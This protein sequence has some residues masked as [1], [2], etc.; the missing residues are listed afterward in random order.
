MA[1]ID[2]ERKEG[3]S[4]WGWLVGAL[5]VALLAWGAVEL[6]DAGEPELAEVEVTEEPGEGMMGDEDETEMRQQGM[7]MEN[8]GQATIAQALNNPEQW[9]SRTVPDATVPVVEVPTDRGFWVTT[10]G[11]RLFVILI[12]QPREEPKDINSGATVRLTGGTFRNADH[13]P[14]LEG[15][16]LDQQTRQ[17]AQGERIFLVVDERNVEIVDRVGGAM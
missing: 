2:L 17:M 6:M 13:L 7:G 12:D 16:P 3:S 9:I 1:D 15:E 14:D 10:E 8:E 4:A 11:G 5:V